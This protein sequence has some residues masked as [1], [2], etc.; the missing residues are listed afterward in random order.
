M[1]KINKLINEL[2]P[3]G[4]E[5]REFSEICNL[6]AGD[7][8]IKSMMD[9]NFEYPVMGG[10]T[11]PTGYYTKHNYENAITISRAGS[12]GFVNWLPQKFWA[13]DVCFVATQKD[14]KA[15]IKYVYYFVKH[16]SQNFKHH[17]YGGSMPKLD[18]SYLWKLPIP[19]PPISV[20]KEIIK[21]LDSFTELEAELEAELEERK[22]QY[23]YYRYD[24]LTFTEGVEFKKL[25]EITKILRGKRLTKNQLSDDE[26]YP[27]YHGGLE[28][29]GYYGQKNRDASTV[30]VINVGASAG[31][32]GYSSVDFW[33]SDGCYCIK[34]SDLLISR[35]LYYALLC[36][37]NIIRSKVRYAGIPTLDASAVENI[38]IPIPHLKEQERIVKIL[39]KFD[40]LVNDISIG[41]PAELEAR[42][43]Q[44]EYYREKLLT[45]NDVN[46]N[47]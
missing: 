10:G 24:L 25:G 23:Q 38:E 16:E 31:T 17:L 11:S 26:K 39:D 1:N 14:E 21:L 36:Q 43:K 30:M 28:A 29:L 18:K 5:F 34:Y 42:R 13:T 7:R 8:I 20:Q 35:Y 22:K 44:Y 27:V 37:E 4:V 47:G 2:C 3:K 41:L 9:T 40:A 32:V 33:S 15:L 46:T 19:I 45:F 6:Q 12:A